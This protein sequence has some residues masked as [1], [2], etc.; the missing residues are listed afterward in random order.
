MIEIERKFLIDD[1]PQLPLLTEAVIYQGY[2][3]VKPTVR[4]RSTEIAGKTEYVLCFKGKGTLS[5][6]EIEMNLQKEVFEELAELLS[7]PMIR[8]D[9]RVYQL[10]DGHKLECSLVDKGSASEFKYAEVEFQ[11][12]EEASQFDPPTFLG[13]EVTEERSFS[14]GSYWE[15]YRLN[16]E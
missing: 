1:F 9:F 11:S 15:K 12:L 4:I 14:M 6:K 10:P 5:R 2:L 13:R 16:Q 3:S 7:A 8:K